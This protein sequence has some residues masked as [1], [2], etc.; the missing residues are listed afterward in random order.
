M[1]DRVLSRENCWGAAAGHHVVIGG[2]S[3]GRS[4][5]G[6]K[7]AKRQGDATLCPQGLRDNSC[8]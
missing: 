4:C 2:R 5:G 7:E 3:P 1:P 6:R 8:T